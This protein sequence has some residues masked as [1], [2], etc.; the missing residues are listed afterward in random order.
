[1]FLFKNI[2][3]SLFTFSPPTKKTMKSLYTVLALALLLAA[4]KKEKSKEEL[5]VGDWKRK[6][7][8]IDPPQEVNG[9]II[10]NLY[11]QMED[12]EKDNLYSFYDNATYKADEGFSKCDSADQQSF[13]GSWQLLSSE[14]ELKIIYLSD[15]VVYGILELDEDILKLDYSARDSANVLHTITTSFERE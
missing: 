10:T 13:S 2:S 12:C 8:T 7:M 1:M 9:A 6:T 4:C 11:A 3:A 5:L 14:T 15:T